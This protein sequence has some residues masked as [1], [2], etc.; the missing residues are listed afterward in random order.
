MKGL[1]AKSPRPISIRSVLNC[2]DNSGAKELRVI[3][4]KGFGG[5]RKR[6]PKAGLGDVVIC[7]VI[8]GKEKLRHT[9]VW[10]VIVRQK[11]GFRR[12]DG[13]RV[14][15]ADNAAVLVNT[16]TLDPVGTE[17]RSVV[18]KEVTEKYLTIGKISNVVV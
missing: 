11:K 6:H 17:I 2:A 18:A 1:R 9:V 13:T 10:A 8:K 14:K 7:S 15:F 16:K 5:R 12:P 4:V 3:N